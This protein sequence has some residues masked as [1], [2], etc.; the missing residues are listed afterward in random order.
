LFG[1]PARIATKSFLAGQFQVW[2]FP[3]LTVRP[4]F[5]SYAFELA[6]AVFTPEVIGQPDYDQ[7]RAQFGQMVG[8]DSGFG[9]NAAIPEPSSLL[10]LILAAAS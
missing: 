8:S 7:W 6:S 4:N 5:S 1:A 9:T 10:L 2:D 3:A